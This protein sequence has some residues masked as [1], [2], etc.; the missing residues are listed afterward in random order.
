MSSAESFLND[1]ERAFGL[2]NIRKVLEDP[3]RWTKAVE[4][5]DDKGY[6][7]SVYS[8]TASSF[9]LVGAAYRSGLPYDETMV[10][11]DSLIPK[12]ALSNQIYYLGTRPE[13]YKAVT[14]WNDPRE[15]RHCEVLQL[16]DNGIKRFDPEYVPLRQT[17]IQRFRSWWSKGMWMKRK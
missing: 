10:L 12:G 7:T 5:R 1:A 9:C 14:L 2:R 11:L 13:P 8:E 3:T 4:A 16:L 6:M 17:L 15:R